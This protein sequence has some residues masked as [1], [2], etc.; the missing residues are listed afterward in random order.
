MIEL[1]KPSGDIERREVEVGCRDNQPRIS[2][3][4]QSECSHLVDKPNHQSG[5][6]VILEERN[7]TTKM[8]RFI[9]SRGGFIRGYDGCSGVFPESFAKRTAKESRGLYKMT[10]SPTLN[11]SSPRTLLCRE[12]TK[13]VFPRIYKIKRHEVPKGAAAE[14]K[15]RGTVAPIQHGLF[16]HVR[17]RSESFLLNV[18]L[19]FL[20]PDL[21]L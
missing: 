6:R 1:E 13:H 12:S 3:R 11:C 8:G 9:G 17:F 15:T 19:G 20:S 16:K 7:P 10:L 4:C 5:N 2:H 18:V 14:A 21:F